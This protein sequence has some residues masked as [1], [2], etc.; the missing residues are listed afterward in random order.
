MID[1]IAAFWIV[2]SAPIALLAGRFIAN[3]DH[4]DAE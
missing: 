1:L 4:E 2:L 3:Q